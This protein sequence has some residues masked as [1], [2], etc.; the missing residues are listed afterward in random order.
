LEVAPS[1]NIAPTTMQPV[2]R[3]NRDTG[4]REMVAMRWGMVPKFAKSIADFKGFPTVL[5]QRFANKALQVFEGWNLL[6]R[7]MRRVDSCCCNA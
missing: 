6:L 2:I 5:S 3:N 4:E 1:H 7:S